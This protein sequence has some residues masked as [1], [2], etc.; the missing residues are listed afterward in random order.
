MT[1][2]R[3]GRILD[4]ALPVLCQYGFAKTTMADIARAA[5]MSRASIYLYF[6]TKEDLFRAG[7]RRAH[8]RALEH[9]RAVL[10]A[11]G[12]SGVVARISAA[13]AA[14]FAALTELVSG[15]AHASELFD[16]GFT[17]TGDIVRDSDEALVAMIAG[18]LDRA[19]AA[20]Q[21]RLAGVDASASDAARLLLAVAAGL[22]QTS[23]DPE[24][25]AA[26]RALFFRLVSA[27][28][29]QP[30]AAAAPETTSR[31]PAPSAKVA[32]PS[33]AAAGRAS[34]T[35]TRS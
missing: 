29:E 33:R 25:W 11:P 32:G 9:A 30:S 24:Q 4:A 14:Y 7:A 3:D 34:G 23:P 17:V 1:D 12:D 15:S 6:P 5:G 26:H 21:A 10:A 2:D 8:S 31:P 18:A 35:E 28:I 20:G 27:A 22:R 13:M 16:A 19:V